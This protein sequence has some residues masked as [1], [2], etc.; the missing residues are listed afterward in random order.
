MRRLRLKVR[1]RYDTLIFWL[2]SD[3]EVLNPRLDARVDQM[4]EVSPSS[5][6]ILKSTL[7]DYL[8]SKV[9]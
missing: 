1:S 8:T 4:L 3:P 2:F 5:I 7:T 9:F 6:R